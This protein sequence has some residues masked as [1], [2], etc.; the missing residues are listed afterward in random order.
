MI[1]EGWG[2]FPNGKVVYSQF[3]FQWNITFIRGLCIP[4]SN[5]TGSNWI[6]SS[7]SSDKGAFDKTE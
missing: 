7:N 5:G 4:L 2:D 6:H 1:G 3:L